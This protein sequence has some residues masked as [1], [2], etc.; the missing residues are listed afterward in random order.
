MLA[1]KVYVVQISQLEGNESNNNVSTED[2][3]R[4]NEMSSYRQKK[5]AEIF[6]PI[7][8][9]MKL[10]GQFFGEAALAEGGPRMKGCISHFYSAL[11]VLGQWLVVALG[12]TSHFY[13]GFSSMNV[14]F[15]LLVTTVWYVQCASSTT[16]CLLAFPLTGKKPSRFA[17]F[18]SCFATTATELDGM[19]KNAVKGLAMACL[20]AVINTIVIVLFSAINKGIISVLPPWNRHPSMYFI[21][22]VMELVFVP[23][24]S[25]VWTLSPLIFCVTCMLL[26]KMFDT[27]QNKV[28]KELIQTF[29]IASLRQEHLKLCEMLELANAAF[30]PLLFVIISLDIPLMCVNLHQLIKRSSERETIE[31]LGYIYWNVCI[32]TLL[33]VIFIFGNRV[34]E[35][36]SPCSLLQKCR[37]GI[38][39]HVTR[40]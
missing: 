37:F 27:L 30:S 5:L 13:I 20:A 15:F 2:C 9:A 17:R 3:P 8:I 40:I 25:F 28:S 16:V 31:I 19:K 36:V 11:A 39:L 29:T 18:L 24:V 35:K 33:V 12:I 10:T 14:F 21:V 4:E 22:R 6:R 32:S 1:Q 26:E 34:N 23:L 38:S 7:L